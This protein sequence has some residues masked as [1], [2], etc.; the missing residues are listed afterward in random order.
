MWKKGQ[1]R[2]DLKSLII[3]IVLSVFHPATA[4]VK[5]PGMIYILEWTSRHKEPFR[6]MPMKRECFINRRCRYQNCYLTDNVDYFD[7]ITD[8]DVILFNLVSL[9]PRKDLAL[10]EARNDDQIYVF[11]STESAANYAVGPDYNM[12]FNWTWTYKLNSD[13]PFFYIAVWNKEGK[14]IGPATNIT[15]VN[16]M[17]PTSKYVIN[18][19]RN[20]RIAA[21]WFASNCEAINQRLEFVAKLREEMVPYGLKLDIFG[22]CGNLQCPRGRMQDCYGL[23]ETNYYFYIAFE[24][25]FSEDYITEKILTAAEHYTVPVLFGGANYSRYGVVQSIHWK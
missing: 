16:N 24:N 11:V 23:L 25:S 5:K 22:L 3:I 6:W 13:V 10:P 1:N 14:L 20:K 9:W 8:F 7:D 18:K 2:R 4:R 15:W 17:K 19:L 12:F 21:A